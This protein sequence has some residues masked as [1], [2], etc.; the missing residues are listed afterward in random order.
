MLRRI[1]LVLCLMLPVIALAEERPRAGLIWNRSGLPATFPLVVKSAPGQD[2]VLFVD[3]PGT[4]TPVMA[5]YIHGG[6]HF[7]LLLPPGRWQ[8]RFAYGTEWQ[9]EDNLFGPR[10]GWTRTETPL[11]FRIIGIDRRRAYVVTLIEQDGTVRIADARPDAECQM[12]L[13]DSE[14]REWPEELPGM[15]DE[16]R[17][18][19]YGPQPEKPLNER[20]RL[21]YLDSRFRLFTHLCA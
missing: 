11:D 2:Y 18:M 1:A 19:L 10:T 3:D 7:R 8:L 4:D 13:W 20:L 16:R 9:G 17:E 6:D 12:V 15:S 5:G 21:R 14:I